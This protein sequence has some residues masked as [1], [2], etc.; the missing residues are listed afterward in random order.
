MVLA[1]YGTLDNSH[2]RNLITS[3]SSSQAAEAGAANIMSMVTG[4]L[5]L[6]LRLHAE[7]EMQVLYPVLSTRLG[8]EGAALAQRALAVSL[9]G[10]HAQG[11]V[12]SAAGW[13]AH[14]I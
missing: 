14:R 11:M 3:S 1:I 8:A 6:D 2:L 7:A 9:G 4:A 10:M 5:A 13:Q 12:W